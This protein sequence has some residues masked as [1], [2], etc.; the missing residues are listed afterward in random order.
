[1]PGLLDAPG[2]LTASCRLGS[3]WTGGSAEMSLLGRCCLSA[4]VSSDTP[5]PK[6]GL[7]NKSSAS[8][9]F[10]VDT[11]HHKHAPPF[12]TMH[13]TSQLVCHCWVDAI[14]KGLP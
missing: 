6:E 1:M 12:N 3:L 13:A 8:W 2:V 4:A 11:L 9:N 7:V 14:G 5:S 10:A